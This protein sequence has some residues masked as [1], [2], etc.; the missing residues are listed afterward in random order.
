VPGYDTKC[1]R[2]LCGSPY[3]PISA[4]ATAT[5]IGARRSRAYEIRFLN[6]RIRRLGTTGATGAIPVLPTI[7]HRILAANLSA[8]AA[9]S[10]ATKTDQTVAD[11]SRRLTSTRRL[12]RRRRRIR[13]SRHLVSVRLELLPRRREG[14]STLWVLVA[15]PARQPRL[16]SKL[17]RCSGGLGDEHPRRARHHERGKR[18]ACNNS[19]GI[20]SQ[21]TVCAG[22]RRAGTQL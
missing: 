4:T 16:R 14:A 18:A 17:L 22:I 5:F 11:D 20:F 8:V 10:A 3:E 9:T 1:R 15:C 12:F 7:S 21:L 19:H 2:I 13:L 6:S